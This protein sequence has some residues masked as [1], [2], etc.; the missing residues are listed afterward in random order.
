MQS[1]RMK[2]VVRLPD[3]IEAFCDLWTLDNERQK[4]IRQLPKL[5]VS[6]GIDNSVA[7]FW[8]VWM[9]ALA[10]TN[11]KLLAYL[12]YM[13]ERLLQMKI[14]LRPMGSIYLHCDPTCSHYIKV[15]MDGI[16][17]EKN[18]RNEIVWCYSRPSAPNQRQLSRVHD[19]IFWYTNGNQWVFNPD[20]I[21]Q[22]YANSSRA[23]EGYSAEASKVASGNVELNTKGKFPESWIYI[24]PLKGNSREYKGY[25][26]QKPLKLIHRIIK[27][28]SNEGDVVFDPF[29]GCATTLVAAQELNR[30]WIGID[31]AI[32]AIKRVSAIR[33]QEDCKLTE[34]I[35]Y[36]ISGIPQTLEGAKDLWNRDTYQ[37]QK[38]AVEMVDG[39]VTAGRGKDGGVDGESISLM[40]KVTT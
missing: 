16:F 15:I 6:H 1:T 22:P 24:P 4:V 13:T 30:K 7:D 9:K 39:F 8:K 38:W 28:S 17:G 33:L 32:H 19:I 40:T 2:L 29:C 14:I 3:Q 34:G 5:M 12:S 27:A 10:N 26:T 20:P 23:R 21:R 18:F 35:D 37:F 11:P 36:E 31:I 25:P